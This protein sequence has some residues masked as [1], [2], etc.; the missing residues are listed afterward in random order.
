MTTITW[1]NHPLS[2]QYAVESWYRKSASSLVAP[3]SFRLLLLNT[4]GLI[5]SSTDLSTVTKIDLLK[6]ELSEGNGY[7]AP[8]ITY[9]AG[10]WSTGNK[11]YEI[12]GSEI[13]IV[14]SGSGFS[15]DVLVEWANPSTSRNKTVV[16]MTASNNQIEVTGHGR[17]VNDE[18]MFT[19]TGTIGVGLSKN[20]IY[21]V[22]TVVD[23]NNFTVSAT[24]GGSEI[25]ITSD[26]SG[27]LVC[28]FTTGYPGKIGFLGFTSTLNAGDEININFS[29]YRLNSSSST[30]V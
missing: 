1:K 28:R 21:Y 13:S 27:S 26:S 12:A 20:T 23:A 22:K 3:D 6:Y 15:Y 7:D 14:A 8:T 5:T 9:S 17:S 30:G 10:S 11:R 19:G 24:A 29:H 25:D 4:G 18:V 16:G 2:I